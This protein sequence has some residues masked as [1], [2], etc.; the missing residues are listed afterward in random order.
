[1][2]RAEGGSHAHLTSLF[3]CSHLTVVMW[4]LAIKGHFYKFMLPPHDSHVAE[5]VAVVKETN[6]KKSKE[7]P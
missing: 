7:A 4:S 1:M 3:E 5:E 2:M 6:R